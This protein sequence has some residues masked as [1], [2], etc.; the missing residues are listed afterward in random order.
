MLC[1]R[2]HGSSSPPIVI[3]E[4]VNQVSHVHRN[5][6]ARAV[7]LRPLSIIPQKTFPQGS[8]QFHQRMVPLGDEVFDVDTWRHARD[9]VT[10]SCPDAECVGY[11]T[12]TRDARAK[13]LIGYL[14]SGVALSTP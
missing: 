12:V 13:S 9:H 5:V 7:L 11:H 8:C 4:A 2:S 3:R 14:L 6:G 1:D 10:D